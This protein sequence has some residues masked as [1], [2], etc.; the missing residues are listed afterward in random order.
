MKQTLFLLVALLVLA[1]GTAVGQGYR[2]PNGRPKPSA[3]PAPK[4]KAPVRNAARP[5]AKTPA[6]VFAPLT[7]IRTDDEPEP[8]V[9]ARPIRKVKIEH[10]VLVNYRQAPPGKAAQQLIMDEEDLPLLRY[11]TPDQLVGRREV[12]VDGLSNLPAPGNDE[13]K[14]RLVGTNR[15]AT[16]ERQ[17]AGDGQSTYAKMK[18]PSPGF[19]YVALESA[20][21]YRHFVRSPQKEG[22][23]LD[24]Q[25]NAL[26]GVDSVRAVYT[27]RRID[28][29][30]RGA[31]TGETIR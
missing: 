11:L 30:E 12:F 31:G 16:G 6:K 13:Q 23:M 17:L 7:T 19:L 15:L 24:F 4:G 28:S 26:P 21:E 14:Y 25:V 10:P 5:P 8:V 1:L 22:S 18:I 2:P 29:A 27:L 9:R 20:E 3:K